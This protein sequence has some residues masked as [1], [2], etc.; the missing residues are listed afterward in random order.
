MAFALFDNGTEARQS[1][2]VSAA[3]KRVFDQI[4]PSVVQV[5]SQGRG[6]GAGVIWRD[7]GAVLTNYHVVD[8]RGAP[9]QV[10]LADG[11]SLD[12]RVANGNRN[13]DLALLQVEAESLPA[14]LVADSS[15]LRIGELVFAVGHPWGQPNMITAGIVSGLGS[16]PIQGSDRRAEFI[17]SDVRLAPGNSGGPLLNADGAVIGINAMIF[18]GDLSVAIPSH[19]ASTW[20]A[21]I[22]SRRVL[23]GVGV[24]PVQLPVLRRSGRR[25]GRAAGLLIV[26]VS[27][28]GPAHRAGVHVGDV[29]LTVGGEA[30]VDTDTLLD[31]L[32]RNASGEPVRLHMV[33]DG[34]VRE[35][36]VQLSEA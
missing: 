27:P 16:I 13:L 18:G 8:N 35:V 32:S 3:I 22:P 17:R 29:L 14:A 21:G 4:Q 11:R 33:R 12:A 34:E 25:V 10:L 36:D 19:V 5:H 9:V 15:A 31:T 2:R 7:N 28:D 23:L 30:A 6:G 20:V 26:E 1:D 24:R